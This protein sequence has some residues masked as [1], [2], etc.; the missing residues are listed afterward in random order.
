MPEFKPNQPVAQK[1][2]IV[3]VDV[4]TAAPLPLGANRFRLIVVDDAGNESEPTFLDVVVRDLDKPTAVL[5]VVDANG[6]RIDPVVPRG[7]SFTLSGARSADVAP[8]KVVEYRF[9][10]V[11]RG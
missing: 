9:T 4:S 3:R 8:G 1:E 11:D 7:Q 5:D 6:K 10:L 2:P